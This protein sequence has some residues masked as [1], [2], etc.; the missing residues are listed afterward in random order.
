M[1]SALDSYCNTSGG[2]ETTPRSGVEEPSLH[3]G[4]SGRFVSFA[5]M[6]IR[7]A[8]ISTHIIRSLSKSYLYL[9]KVYPYLMCL[10]H[11]YS[12]LFISQLFIISLTFYIIS[13]LY[14]LT[15]DIYATAFMSN[16]HCV[17]SLPL[18][19]PF[20]NNR[21]DQYDVPINTSFP[22]ILSS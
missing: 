4:E 22:S 11:L 6:Y 18:Q 17:A 8:L 19:Y 15:F 20:Y 3:P 9:P 7:C 14:L 13:C 1:K 5:T 16:L 2:N 10:S 12:Y 21:F